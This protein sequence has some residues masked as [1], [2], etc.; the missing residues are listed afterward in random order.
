MTIFDFTNAMMKASLR[1]GAT[2]PLMIAAHG[3]GVLTPVARH[4][5]VI[6]AWRAGALAE[7]IDYPSDRVDRV[8]ND[9]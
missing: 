3:R 4:H 9:G 1:T 6:G 2:D 5:I 8:S 7:L